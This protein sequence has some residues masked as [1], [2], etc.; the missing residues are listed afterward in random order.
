MLFLNAGYHPVGPFADLSYMD[1]QR[2]VSCNTLHP[3]Y[4]AKVL[5]DQMLA[6]GKLSAIVITSSGLGINPVPGVITYS[7]SKSFVSFLGVGLSY[8]LEGKIDCM[9]WT[10]GMTD[11]KL[12]SMPNKNNNPLIASR[13]EAVDGM[14]RDLGRERI[15]KGCKKH[16]LAL[17]A[18][19]KSDSFAR[20]RL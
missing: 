12:L 20:M 16:E 4:T 11:T 9:S 15:T 14:L 3:I 18:Y 2:V 1:I 17:S 6:R 10:L 7:S 19:A 8:E 13:K 5:V